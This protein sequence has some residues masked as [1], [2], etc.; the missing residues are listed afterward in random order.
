MG[1]IG[2]RQRHVVVIGLLM[3]QFHHKVRGG[4][5]AHLVVANVELNVQLGIGLSIY[6]FLQVRPGLFLLRIHHDSGNVFEE[7]TSWGL[8]QGEGEPP[9]KQKVVL[10][11]R[12]H[13]RPFVRKGIERRLFVVR[14]QQQRGR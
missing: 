14:K 3:L 5:E 4:Q 12:H 11:R 13:C 7:R 8:E 2:S 9:Q 10:C 1:R 6:Y